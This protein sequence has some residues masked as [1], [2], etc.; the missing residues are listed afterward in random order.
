MA[1]KS[2]KLEQRN[3]L[4]AKIMKLYASRSGRGR[5]PVV[6]LEDFFEGN[7]DEESLAPNQVDEGRAKLK[8]CYRILKAI[9]D[10]VD[11]QDVLVEIHE[12]PDADDEEDFDL[13]PSSVTVFILTKASTDDVAEWTEKLVPT[14]VLNG[15]KPPPPGAPKL[16]PGMR[17][18]ALWW[19]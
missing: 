8:D 2:K 15:W 14:E 18:R 6:S 11:V 4:I 5:N 12:T 10:R 13:W 16:K 19:D 9:R 7:F 17:V 1:R 3:A